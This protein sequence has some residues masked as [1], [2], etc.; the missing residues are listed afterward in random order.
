[1]PNRSLLTAVVSLSVS[2]AV[3]G[4]GAA[5]R[6]GSQSAATPS[7]TGAAE[8]P[9]LVVL[10]SPVGVAETLDRLE[11]ALEENGQDVV[12]R[13]D[14]AANAA[15]VGE[16]LRPTQLL[17]LGNPALGTT[18]IQAT[19]TIGIDLPQKFLAWEDA[20]GQVYLGYND[21]AYLAARHGV[22]EGDETVQQVSDALAM[23]ARGAT[24]P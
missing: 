21:P 22:E 20:T 19:Q 6:A 8:V 1:M 9:G 23:L 3:L 10:E 15:G 12:A 7:P 16:S 24:E 4:A 17:L 13:V 11:A 2:L 14:H 5:V 18:L